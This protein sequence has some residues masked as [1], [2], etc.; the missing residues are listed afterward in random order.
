MERNE[1]I[2]FI[3]PD[4]E[5]FIEQK[6]WYELKTALSEWPPQDLSHLIQSLKDDQKIIVFR[7]LPRDVQVEVFSEIDFE[8]QERLLHQMGDE[9]VRNV[10]EELEPDDRASLF[11][12]LPGQLV[13][14]LLPMLSNEERKHTLKLLGYPENTVGRLMTPYYATTNSP[15]YIANWTTIPSGR[16]VTSSWTT[17]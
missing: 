5:E 13:Q 6:N 8:T 10:I 3:L 15:T 12:E 7:L 17:N 1:F 11:E 14:K 4:I 16:Y 9:E 2:E